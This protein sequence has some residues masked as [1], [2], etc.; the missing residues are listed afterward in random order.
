MP[1]ARAPEARAA[2]LAEA[3]ADDEELR[4]EVESLL[5]QPVSVAGALDGRA[6]AVATP[7]V[8]DQPGASLVG[9]R[10]GIYQVTALL[11]AGGMGE[12]YRARD[13]RLRRDVALKV[14]PAAFTAD[15]DRL[16]R[17][18]REARV[19]AA[20]NHPHIAA[21]YGVEPLDGS[22]ALI[23]ELVEGETLAERIR[24]ASSRKSGGL[25]LRDA[26]AIARQ[27]ADALDAAHEKGIIHRD[28]KPANIKIT[29]D[30]AVKILDFGLAKLAPDTRVGD[31]ASAAPTMTEAGT[32]EG[33]I[34]G[35][36]AY[37]SPEQARG[38]PVDKRTDI[39]ALGCVLYELL[40]GRAVFARETITDTLAAVLEREPDWS[41]LPHDA[42][43]GV[44][45]LLRRLLD[46]D[47]KR[48]L[49]DIGDAYL[50]LDDRDAAQPVVGEP[51]KR[52]RFSTWSPAGVA[53]AVASA[54][55]LGFS[56][57]RPGPPTTEQSPVQF[58][59]APPAQERLIGT[60][61]PSPNGKQILLLIAEASGGS[62]LWLRS[63]VSPTLQRI[64]GTDG[65]RNPFWSPDGRYVGFGA[66]GRLKK[67][68]VDAG[69]VQVICNCI[70]GDLQGATWNAN[71]VIVFAPHNRAP[72]HRV[73]AAGGTAAPVT[74]LD[75]ARNENSHRWPHFLPDGNRF[76]Y[77]ARSDV[78]GNTGVYVG[79]I[80]SENRQWLF[81]AQSSATYVP[82]GY[83][84]FA[85][86]GALVA[87]R[88][89]PDGLAVSDQP[90]VV[91][92]DVAHNPSG[93]VAFFSLSANGEVLA[94]RHATDQSS[95][96]VW[97]DRAGSRLD[98]VGSAGPFGGQLRLAPDG[99][100]AALMRVDAD[101]GNRDIWLIDLANGGLTRLTAHPASDWWPVWSPDSAHVMFAS[102]RNGASAVFRTAVDRI[103]A[104][105][106]VLESG[107]PSGGRFPIDW[108]TD[109]RF[110]TVGED[111]PDDQGDWM[112]VPL[113][114]KR[115]ER[116]LL[117]LGQSRFLESGGMFSPDGRW[118][119]YVSNESG[120]LEVYVTPFGGGAKYPVSTTGGRLPIW[121]RDGRELFFLS[122][123]NRL[124]V[125]EVRTDDTFAVGAP[126]GLFETCLTAV[127][128]WY[129]WRYDITRDGRRSLWLCPAGQESGLVTV[130]LHWTATLSGR[131]R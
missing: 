58:T 76:L 54:A 81:E 88:F 92:G 102:D 19:L 46:K 7:M 96:L 116:K 33:L 31:G 9:R 107:G 128:Q 3:Y 109:G 42:P 61:V 52:G 35:T 119:A 49:R 68:D 39:W 83:I 89:D 26:L 10:V 100:R 48:R 91:V 99:R 36:A 72:L 56:L 21:I 27:M 108:S 111:R 38:Q 87:Q 60:P 114:G 115:S 120:P 80:D 16:A 97:F 84:L 71:G 85:R 75:V 45:R 69:A 13:T 66:D 106:P 41:L 15:P 127:P 67:L 23:L 14:L 110:L 77:T 129:Q 34:V 1:H 8:S 30:G 103:G 25:R 47:S 104:E 86:D 50:D 131:A 73:A 29:P 43:A 62:A 94:Y 126:V 82:P 93:A 125:A 37:M 28:L 98:A 122:A 74:S 124:M 5:A 121:S 90:V 105:E 55:V 51:P 118:L 32:R 53:L 123:D 11:G 70:T 64:G 79:S 65:A 112:I 57:L 6:W 17:F 78:S 4:R 2:F 40:T 22:T 20:L 18:E 24:H 95:Q 12:V 63:L 101:D 130:T 117:P 59:I 113:M 44:Q